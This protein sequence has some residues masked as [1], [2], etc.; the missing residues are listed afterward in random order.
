MP[1]KPSIYSHGLPFAASS[2]GQVLQK[3]QKIATQGSLQP[4]GSMPA[5]L[6]QPGLLPQQGLL[7]VAL[8]GAATDELQ[9]GQLQ[10]PKA[11]TPGLQEDST[12][13]K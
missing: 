4:C 11:G 1:R 9:E 3:D 12:Y 8:G 2:H 5:P 10:N 13:T 6:P 7:S